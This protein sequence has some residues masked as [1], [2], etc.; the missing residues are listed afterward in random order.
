MNFSAAWRLPET[1][2]HHPEE[3]TLYLC[4]CYARGLMLL[5]VRPHQLAT[6]WGHRN[7]AGHWV[8]LFWVSLC[9]CVCLGCELILNSDGPTNFRWTTR[10]VLVLILPRPPPPLLHPAHSTTNRIHYRPIRSNCCERSKA[11]KK[12]LNYISIKFS[13]IKR[14]VIL[15]T[16]FRSW[17]FHIIIY[18]AKMLIGTLLVAAAW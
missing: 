15:D 16:C 1:T 3:S 6:F 18:C 4:V 9:V 8:V 2:T 5:S 17:K 12:G 14:R 11:F 10:M 13:K 7:L